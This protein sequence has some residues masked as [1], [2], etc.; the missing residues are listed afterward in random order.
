MARPS[1]LAL[2][3]VDD[4]ATSRGFALLEQMLNPVLA[5]KRLEYLTA[6]PAGATEADSLGAGGSF[7]TSTIVTAVASPFKPAILAIVPTSSTSFGDRGMVAVDLSY[8]YL[9]VGPNTWR[10]VALASW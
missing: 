7:G 6:V 3:S 4:P 1:V 8:L 9:C 2:P 10:R 5:A